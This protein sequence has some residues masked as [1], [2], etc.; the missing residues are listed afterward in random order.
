MLCCVTSPSSHKYIWSVH[1]TSV[2]MNTTHAWERRKERIREKRWWEQR[3]EKR[4]RWNEKSRWAVNRCSLMYCPSIA[5]P[6]LPLPHP[7]C[8][9]F[10][11]PL[12]PVIFNSPSHLLPPS[13]HSSPSL[14]HYTVK[15][16]GWIKNSWKRNR[17][18]PWQREAKRGF[19]FFRTL[20]LLS[21]PS[22]NPHMVHGV[23][24]S[25]CKATI[26]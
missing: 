7:P 11:P 9:S 23:G 1:N 12:L 13:L 15:D 22:K 6:H 24:V 19:L 17:K 21:V 26:F 14:I 8:N 16:K 10:S 5:P 2:D 4:K 20:Q 3:G 25:V 18:K